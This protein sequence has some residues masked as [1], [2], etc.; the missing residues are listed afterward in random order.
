MGSPNLVI[1]LTSHSAYLRPAPGR[2]AGTGRSWPTGP[3]DKDER[4]S[5]SRR[6]GRTLREFLAY[7]I[8]LYQGFLGVF[9]WLLIV[10]GSI[11]LVKPWA[12]PRNLRNLMA[13]RGIQK[14][15]R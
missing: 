6:S 3:G 15:R 9:R 11:I 8:S 14:S 2:G 10:V 13:E 5:T 12:K 1:Y 4:A 7:G